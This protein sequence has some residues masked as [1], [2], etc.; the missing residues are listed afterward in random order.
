[1]RITDVEVDRFG[2]WD[3]LKLNGL[4]EELTVFYGPNEAGKTTLM[5][6]VRSVLYGFTPERRSRY[7]QSFL[8]GRVGGSIR[9]ADN[10]ERLSIARHATG[11]EDLGTLVVADHVNARLNERR[12]VDLLGGVDETT[13]VNVF[14]CGLRE[15]QELGTLSDTDAATLLYDLTLGA[16]RVSLSA[17]AREVDSERSRLLSGDIRHS[18]IAQLIA[19]RERLRAEIDT[20]GEL[21]P[22]Y[23]ELCARRTQLDREVEQHGGTEHIDREI[24]VVEVAKAVADPWKQRVELDRHLAEYGPNDAS[25]AELLVALDGIDAKLKERRRRRR[26]LRNRRRKL[27]REAKG[28]A[29]NDALCQQAAKLDALSE[30]QAWMAS[31]SAQ[32]KKL[33][34]EVAELELTAEATHTVWLVPP[35]NAATTSLPSAPG[36]G[37]IAGTIANAVGNKPGQ[38]S[39][40][41]KPSIA[42]PAGQAVAAPQLSDRQMSDLRVASKTLSESM[43]RFRSLKGDLGLSGEHGTVESRIRAVLGDRADDGLHGAVEQAGEIVSLLRRRIQLEEKLEQ[44][45]RREKD[46][47]YE[48]GELFEKQQLPT[49]MIVAFGACFI[50]GAALVLLYLASWMVPASVTGSLGWPIPYIGMALMAMGALGKSG[51]ERSAAVELEQCRRQMDALAEQLQAAREERDAIDERLPE[52]GGPLAVRLRDAEKDLTELEALLPLQSQREAAAHLSRDYTR[53]KAQ[54][55]ADAISARK[56]WK[57]TLQAVGWPTKVSPRQFHDYR[58]RYVQA[59]ESA[60]ALRVKREELTSRQRDYHSVADRIFQ[61]ATEVGMPAATGDA[62]AKLKEL[63]STLVEH[64]QRRERR[65][66]LRRQSIEI[67]RKQV[68][69]ERAI[70][71]IARKREHLLLESGFANEDEARQRALRYAEAQNLQR[72]RATLTQQIALML[73]MAAT[74]EMVGK[75]LDGRDL[76]ETHA[77]LVGS[78]ASI[79]T[80][81]QSKL[82]QRA[83]LTQQIRA[84]AEDRRPVE[85][86]LELASVERRLEQQVERWRALAVAGS[87]LGQVQSSYERNRQPIALRE[88]TE[89]LN[90]MTGGKYV[91]VWTP[92]GEPELRVD[93]AGGKSLSVEVLSAGTREQLFLSLRLALVKLYAERGVKLPLVLDDVLV[94]FDNL[95]AK[96]A[97]TVLRDFARQ[98]HQLLVFTCHEHIARL[99]KQLKVDVREL[100]ING[101]VSGVL[102]EE[103]EEVPPPRK[104]R[105]PR[106]VEEPVLI[107]LPPRVELPPVPQPL[108]PVELR[109]QRIQ[110]DAVPFVQPPPSPARIKPQRVRIDRAEHVETVELVARTPPPKPVR[111]SNRKLATRVDRVEWDAEEF[112]GELKDQIGRKV[113]T[114]HSSSRPHGDEDVLEVDFSKDNGNSVS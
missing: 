85:K 25:A 87:L 34:D 79:R 66:V 26:I 91:R 1:M 17:A 86:R 41:A 77:Q 95:R 61:L 113:I 15:M 58:R 71:A 107:T 4:S 101:Q 46:L 2:V 20:L 96:A 50:F 18:S 19:D 59:K 44:M 23:L 9:V 106:P 29:V 42:R 38:S 49:W 108:S 69:Y 81:L 73:G 109:F 39:Q 3:A 64:T 57:S 92:L 11:S 52:A 31:L 43:R 98:G 103:V 99:F 6:F 13:Y 112:E 63:Q 54:A 88:A 89:F 33:E 10:H 37:T 105:E 55:K 27:A 84:L 74:E 100:P 90:R 82:E 30:Q 14:A 16:D 28:I 56:R 45:V 35:G 7:L 104:K 22:R 65:T 24:R 83:E 102:D 40:P 80:S 72:Q 78:L 114:T 60:A 75:Y 36:S 70:T 21:T 47:N 110:Y 53:R 97:A 76:N 111:K 51:M 32:L 5:Q 8:T 67:R 48:S 62:V 94:N 68:R 12:L 93:E